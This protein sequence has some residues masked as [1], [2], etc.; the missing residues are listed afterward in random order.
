M[1]DKPFVGVWLDHRMAQLFWA[2]EEADIKVQ[3]VQ[4]EFQEEGEPVD[5]IEPAGEF[6][7]AGGVQHA[8]LENRRAEQLKHYYK[9]LDKILRDADRIFLFGPGQAKKE[10]ANFLKEDKGLRARIQG[11][12]N[13]DKKLTQNQKAARVR[14]FF[15]L[16]RTMF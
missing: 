4:S 5:G 3:Q 6:A 14:E 7:H 11:V 2:D 10:L 15:E 1:R 16:P 9:K 13:A 12:E 8:R